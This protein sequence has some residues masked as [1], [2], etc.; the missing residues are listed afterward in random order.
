[1]S[2]D[3]ARASGH[4]FHELCAALEELLGGNVRAE[5]LDR[6]PQGRDAVGGLREA[7]RSHRL[8]AGRGLALGGLVQALDEAT[9]R[10]GFHVLRTWDPVAHRFIADPT[11]VLLLGYLGP[12]RGRDLRYEH[13]VLLDTHF[14]FLLVLLAMRAWDT[15]DPNAAMDQLDRLLR[16][17]QGP[18]GSQRQFVRGWPMLIGLAIAQYQ[19]DER[20]F[21]PL[22]DKLRTLD[23]EHE[24]DVALANAANF[25]AHLRW[26]SRF[27]YERDVERMRTDNVVDYPWVLHAAATLARELDAGN[28]TPRLLEG[29]L[30]VLGADP[31]LVFAPGEAPGVVARHEAERERCAAILRAHADTLGEACGAWRPTDDR[32]APLGLHFNFLHNV[33]TATLAVAV[34]DGA[35]N[36]PLDDLLHTTAGGAR[37][38]ADT[39]DVL[40]HQ[41]GMY[42]AHPDRLGAKR[43]PLIVYDA[44]WGGECLSGVADALGG[45]V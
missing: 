33:L 20:G 41:L 9:V 39:P 37:R 38:L 5:Y 43:A 23:M 27:M 11:S 16:L 22:L 12:F 13:A 26:G 34:A 6:L 7:M 24:R 14:L 32:F 19:P 25:G 18:G 15:E 4:H 17:L 10:E 3:A 35:P 30:Q 1:M 45:E 36:V 44:A 31:G 28:R 8:H 2:A 29:L 42:A 21:D 40:A